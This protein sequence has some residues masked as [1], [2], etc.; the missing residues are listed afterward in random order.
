MAKEL[1]ARLTERSVQQETKD[2][3]VLL[4]LRELEEAKEVAQRLLLEAQST[5]ASMTAKSD[6]K[7]TAVK[8]VKAVKKTPNNQPVVGKEALVTTYQGMTMS[9]LKKTTKKELENVLVALGVNTDLSPLTK[10]Q[11]NDLL[12]SKIQ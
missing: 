11:L 3:K 4:Q 5:L 12:Q 8:E 7:D 1:K 10:A 2:G 9:K 6:S